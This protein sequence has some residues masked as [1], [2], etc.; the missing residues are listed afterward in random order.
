MQI[1]FDWN[2]NLHES[3]K[4]LNTFVH[5]RIIDVVCHEWYHNAVFDERCF[6]YR[7]ILVTR[8]RNEKWKSLDIWERGARCTETSRFLAEV[9]PLRRLPPETAKRKWNEMRFCRSE[10]QEEAPSL[11][12]KFLTLKNFLLQCIMETVTLNGC[13]FLI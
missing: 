13:Q 6:N 11:I 10:T 7:G 9:R 1:N 12:K 4:Y 8:L 3:Y 2:A 5:L